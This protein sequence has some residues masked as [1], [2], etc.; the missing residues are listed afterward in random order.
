MFTGSVFHDVLENIW[1]ILLFCADF[2]C[3]M[4]VIFVGYA[5]GFGCVFTSVISDLI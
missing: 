5:L 2:H 1:G 4:Q 3:V